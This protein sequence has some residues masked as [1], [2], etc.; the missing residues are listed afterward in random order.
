MNIEH[1]PSFGVWLTIALSLALWTLIALGY[2]HFAHAQG[3][4]VVTNGQG[5]ATPTD[6]SS[7]IAVTNTFQSVFNAATQGT[8]G[9]G[10]RQSCLIQN[11]GANTM[12][13]WYGPQNGT[14]GTCPSA[15]KGTSFT[16]I[17]PATNVQGGSFSCSNGAG[18]IIQDQIC[19]AGTSPDA[20]TAKQE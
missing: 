12:W 2:S 8:S 15:T 14:G 5:I 9:R 7:T 18:S 13:V 10:G 3:S 6:A 19:V 17:P 20:Y 4:P 1:R 16:L 11:N